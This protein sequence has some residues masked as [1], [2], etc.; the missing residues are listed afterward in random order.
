MKNKKD[1]S[2]IVGNETIIYQT[3]DGHTKIDVAD[4]NLDMSIFLRYIVKSK[5]AA[6]FRRWATERLEEYMIKGFTNV[7]WVA[8][9]VPICFLRKVSTI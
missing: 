3:E 4:Y 6:N 5:I 1:N 2:N 9:I 8:Q 7:K